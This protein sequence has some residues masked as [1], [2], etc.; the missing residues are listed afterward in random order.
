MTVIPFSGPLLL[1][2]DERDRAAA[3]VLRPTVERALASRERGDRRPPARIYSRQMRA[4]LSAAAIAIAIAAPA[5]ADTARSG[6]S[7]ER[8]FF[9][10]RQGVGVEAPLGWTLSL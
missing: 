10:A 7:K 3:R 5:A 6:A 2:G 1:D 4:L 8:R 9:S